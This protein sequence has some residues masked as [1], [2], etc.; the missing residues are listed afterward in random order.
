MI[1]LFKVAVD[2][3]AGPLVAEALRTGVLGHGPR[4]EE[5][6]EALRARLGVPYL[7]TLNNGTSALHLALRLAA[8]PGG[9]GEVLTTP[10]TFE[11][12]NWAILANGLRIR[13]VDVDPGTL[14]MDLDDLAKKISP[15]TR[16]VMVVHW[17]GHPVDLDRLSS[18]L[19]EAEAA[20]G[21]RPAVIE[22]CAQAWGTVCRGR[23]VGAHGN[24]CAF[25]F[26]AT[27]HLACGT[28]GMLVTPDEETLR[29]AL[30]LRFFGIDRKAD[31]VNGDYDVPEWG[32]NFY[33]GELGAAVGL[34]NLASVDGRVEL[35][36]RNAAYY[37]AALAGVP[38][39]ELTTREEG[40]ESSFWLYPVKVA[41]RAGFIRKMTAAGVTVSAVVRRNDTHTCVRDVYDPALPG[42][43]SVHDRVVHIPVGWWVSERDREYVVET[44]RSGW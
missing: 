12:T 36:R 38:G 24:L 21:S 9:G 43:E 1:P 6:E 13:W 42:L 27:K 2:P 44:I 39:V 40:L 19:D 4:G 7:A 17:A 18:V 5:F 25:S 23:P 37:D 22:D 20:H 15:E 30:R 3:G 16:A 26:H 29:R 35:H 14:T 31:R 33:L 8:E 41:D 10:Y 11:A 28:G 34:A 32:Y